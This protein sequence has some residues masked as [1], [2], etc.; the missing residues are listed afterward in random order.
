MAGQPYQI[1]EGETLA[2]LLFAN[3]VN[4]F[5]PEDPLKAAEREARRIAYQKYLA[6]KAADEAADDAAF[7]L[8]LQAMNAASAAARGEA[9]VNPSAPGGAP[10]VAPVGPRP[11]TTEERL[12]FAADME[13]SRLVV[14][15]MTNLELLDKVRIYKLNTQEGR[16]A[17][18][19]NAFLRAVTTEF[20]ERVV[21]GKVGYDLTDL[22]KIAREKQAALLLAQQ[23]IDA[24]F[25]VV[26]GG[27]APTGSGGTGEPP[28]EPVG[29]QFG[30]GVVTGT[31][32]PGY[33]PPRYIQNPDG[34]VTV[35]PGSKLSTPTDPN[36][37]Q[38][39]GIPPGAFPD[40]M[41]RRNPP[42]P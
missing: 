41:F 1:S 4:P 3:L 15:Q 38:R 40:D 42:D 7:Q 28:I 8:R 18:D 31:P 23:L 12:R 5:L 11:M 26:L 17:V 27:P 16:T 9:P 21:A 33:M 39:P 29:P 14:A 24:T 19:D 2:E 20:L 35:L 6:Q 32:M 25:G 22:E 36:A 10:V 13:R 37:P 30:G 34:T